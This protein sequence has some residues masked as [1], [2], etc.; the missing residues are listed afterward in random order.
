MSTDIM[1]LN[2][3]DASLARRQALKLTLALGAALAG[4]VLTSCNWADAQNADHAAHGGHA[5]AGPAKYQDL[6]DAALACVHRGEVCIDHCAK[7]MG[8]G[9]TSLKDCMNSVATMLPMCTAV[10]RFAAFDAPRLKEVT[11]LCVDICA[12]CEKEC[13]KHEEHHAQCKNCAE[14]CAAFIREGRKVLGA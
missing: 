9:D 3:D 13:R 14:S 11:R 10:A 8:T 12:D 4:T 6:I 7:Q 1:Q 5:A 2:H